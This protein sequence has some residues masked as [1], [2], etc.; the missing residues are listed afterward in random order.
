MTVTPTPPHISVTFANPF[1][2]CDVCE[3]W[4]TGYHDQ[5]RCGCDEE[6]RN[7]PCRHPVGVSNVCPSWGPVDGCQCVARFGHREHAAPPETGG[8][9]GEGAVTATDLPET[10]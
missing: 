3:Q 8:M 5:Q 6:K 7:E 1:L 2:V 4:V 9:G 10:S